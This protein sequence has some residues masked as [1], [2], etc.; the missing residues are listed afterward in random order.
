MFDSGVFFFFYSSLA[1]RVSL[2]SWDPRLTTLLF[3]YRLNSDTGRPLEISI[4]IKA[5]FS[6][7][8]KKSEYE[9]LRRHTA[10][11]VNGT[12]HPRPITSFRKQDSRSCTVGN[13]KLYPTHA[14]WHAFQ[15]ITIRFALPTQ[16]IVV[17]VA[18]WFSNYFVRLN[19]YKYVY[20]YIIICV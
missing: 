8:T 7:A 17:V 12:K 13:V 2:R 18:K 10:C 19:L 9:I 15:P 11:D 20:R 3:A 6:Y 1:C 16:I 5:I 4:R 14:F